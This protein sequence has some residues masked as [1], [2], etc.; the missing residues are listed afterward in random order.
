MNEEQVVKMADSVLVG[1][2]VGTIVG[3]VVCAIVL[4]RYLAKWRYGEWRKEFKCRECGAIDGHFM[5][6]APEVCRSCGAREDDPDC[7]GWESV[8]ARKVGRAYVHKPWTW[9]LEPV[10]EEKA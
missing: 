1:M 6:F 7:E 2:G 4:A 5:V 3:V 8:V 9:W 10:W